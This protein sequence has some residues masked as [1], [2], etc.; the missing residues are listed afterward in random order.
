MTT[1]REAILELLNDR[2]A[3]GQ[4][5]TIADLINETGFVQYGTVEKILKGLNQ[6]GYISRLIVRDPLE[7]ITYELSERGC[8]YRQEIDAEIAAEKKRKEEIKKQRIHDLIL[9]IFSVLLSNLDR[10]IGFL[11]AIF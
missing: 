7:P 1:E 6:D 8:F 2:K 4:N 10:I 5:I 11:K 9:V 3:N